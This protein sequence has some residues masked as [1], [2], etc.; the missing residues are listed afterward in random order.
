M[1]AEFSGGEG[2][3]IVRDVGLDNHTI[4]TTNLLIAFLGTERLVAVE[5]SLKFNVDVSRRVINKDTAATIHLVII[6]LTKPREETTS[7]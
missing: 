2:G 1:L 5:T 4:V 7:N 3:T 6:C